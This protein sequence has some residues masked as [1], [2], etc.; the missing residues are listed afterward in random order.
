VLYQM[1]KLMHHHIVHD[2]IGGDDDF[3]VELNMPGMA[4]TPPSTLEGLDAYG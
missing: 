3:P 2:P 1:T 4:A